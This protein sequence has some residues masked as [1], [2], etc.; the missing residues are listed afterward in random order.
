MADM[1]SEEEY[2]SADEQEFDLIDD[3]VNGSPEQC[4]DK[5]LLFEGKEQLGPLVEQL[6][7]K[8]QTAIFQVGPLEQVHDP[9]V[10][11]KY[12]T[13]LK[14]IYDLLV[15]YITNNIPPPQTITETL[16][17]VQEIFNSIIQHLG[18]QGDEAAARM[19]FLKLHLICFPYCQRE[20][21][22]SMD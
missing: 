6:K 21:C 20:N 14:I 11:T 3:T 16:P 2:L 19:A 8:I 17:E 1:A 15:Q 7:S 13:L 9:A 10:L 5:E 18:A 12:K 4:D 22:L